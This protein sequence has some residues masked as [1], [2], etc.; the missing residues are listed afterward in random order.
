MPK[1]PPRPVALPVSPRTIPPD[2]KALSQ[3]VVWAFEWKGADEKWDKPPRNAHGRGYAKSTDPATWATFEDALARFQQGGLDGIGLVLTEAHG[4]VGLDLDHCRNPDTGGIDPWALDIVHVLPTYWEVSPS[5]TGLRGIAH[6]TLPPQ[7]RK[8][9]DVEMYIGGRYL[10]ITGCHLEGTPLTI[11]PCQDAIDALHPRI[12]GTSAPPPDAPQTNGVPSA[13]SDETLLEKALNARNGG[14][15]ARLWAGD[16]RGYPSPSNADEALCCLLAFY[17]RDA[18]QIDRLFRQSPLLREKWDE[19]RG[20]ETY[21]QRT[22]RQALSRVTTHWRSPRDRP[23]EEDGEPRKQAHRTRDDEAAA[24]DPSPRPDDEPDDIHLSDVGNGIRLI[25]RFGRDLRYVEA[26]NKWLAWQGGRWAL[27]DQGT[28]ERYAKLVVAGLYEWANALLDK[29]ASARTAAGASMIDPLAE[30]DPATKTRQEQVDKLLA[31]LK[32]ALKSEAAPRIH[33]MID[34][35]HSEPG[36]SIRHGTLDADPWLLNLEN[37]TLDLRSCIVREPRRED[38]LTKRACVRYDASA[39][40]PRWKAFLWRIMGGPKPDEEGN[41]EE[42]NEQ[43]ERAERLI[44]YL[45][46]AVGYSL[47]GS[48]VEQ[49]L[50]FLH[51]PGANGKSVFLLTLLSLLGDYAMQAIAELLMVR[52]SEQHPTERA[53]LF[54]RRFMVTTEVESGRRLAEVMVKQLT[55]GDRLRARR[56][57]EDFWE[58]EPTH[59]IWLAAN[60]K[61]V[62]RGTDYAIWRRIKLIPFTVTIPEPERD[63]RL[64]EKLTA[65]LPGILNWAIEGCRAWQDSGLQEPPEVTEAGQVYRREMNSIGQFLAECC[66]VKA[67]T[68]S[69]RTQSSVL[70]Q[71]FENWSGEKMTQKEFSERL[72]TAGH[73]KKMGGDGRMYW[74]GIGLIAPEMDST[75]RTEG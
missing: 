28:V 46:R 36:I 58:F 11:E 16:I 55:G 30:P 17:T 33:A 71:A 18:N 48:V 75:E 43:A 21:G 63:Q 64:R 29:F 27:D 69:L 26:W 22:I 41:D 2:L 52:V 1:A 23:D 35:A 67:D 39:T 6:G 3:W 59:K 44:D 32:W 49:V 61:P 19:A 68:P 47:S 40:C 25:H 5:G 45:Q 38:L 9:G 56:M 4:I 24:G 10:T 31:V 34:M 15:L 8:K 20:A 42:L 60:H 13:L 51:G 37:G 7:G 72:V 14:K 12:F 70:H 50:F 62:I 57:R 53:D 74:L 73:T 65:E 54:G 66:W